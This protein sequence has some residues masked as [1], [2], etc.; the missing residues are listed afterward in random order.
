MKF[1]TNDYLLNKFLKFMIFNP[2]W[3]TVLG[4]ALLLAITIFTSVALIPVE[5]SCSYI[6]MVFIDV[7]IILIPVLIIANNNSF[8]KRFL[9]SSYRY[10]GGYD[11]TYY[12][13]LFIKDEKTRQYEKV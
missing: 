7:A 10:K 8:M 11:A 2:Y 12:Q 1:E 6:G 5:C 4:T 3:T 13:D 9:V